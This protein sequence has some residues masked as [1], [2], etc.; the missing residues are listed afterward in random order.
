MTGQTV[1]STKVCETDPTPAAEHNVVWPLSYKLKQVQKD[2]TTTSAPKR[3]W[4]HTLYRGPDDRPVT[5]LYSKNKTE[6]EALAKMFIHEPVVGFDM[7]WPWNSHKKDRLQDKIGLI[8]VACEDK[9]GLFHIGL[10]S[11][12]TSEDL[13]APSLRTIIESPNIAKTGVAVLAAD[14]ARLAKFFKLRPQGAFELSHLHHLVM[15]SARKPDLVNT[16]LISLADLVEHHLGLPLSKG[17]VRTS[18]WSR[19]LN[20]KQRDYA[21]SDAYAGFMLYHCMNAKRALMNPIPPLP[22]HAERYLPL[23]FSKIVPIQLQSETDAKKI[24]TAD[25]FFDTNHEAE[26]AKVIGPGMDH[27]KMTTACTETAAN[28]GTIAATNEKTRAK[29]KAEKA[30]L[31]PISQA[32][33]DLLS[34]RRRALAVEHDVAPYLVASNV[35]L[36]GLARKRPL[37]ASTLLQVKGIGPRQQEKYGDQWLQVIQSFVEDT[38]EDA[39]VATEA[40][41][42]EGLSHPRAAMGPTG[43]RTRRRASRPQDNSPPSSPAF[44]TP[45]RRVPELHTGLSFTLAETKLDPLMKYSVTKSEPCPS[46]EDSPVSVT[47]EA[48]PS[49]KRKRSKS[50]D[51]ARTSPPLREQAEPLTPNSRIFR[52]KLEAYSKRIASMSK[53]RPV[54]PLVSTSV[55]D[56]IVHNPPRTKEELHRIPGITKLAEACATLDKDLLGT[57][58]KFSAA[59]YS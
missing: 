18:N 26:E 50:P 21:A 30:P 32:L 3:W 47:E 28:H 54:E 45:P 41:P 6:S 40:A 43:R 51:R 9:I 16:R 20:Q 12:T 44:G 55:L 7:E 19:A 10:H 13:I 4:S 57:I 17:S 36:E 24:L 42:N 37:D 29:C 39:G 34:Q 14:M 8:Q 58:V 15:F 48:L 31:D 56:H 2:T 25:D 27:E 22:M 23:S 46:S 33:F 59:R 53:P 38:G 1:E 52:S 5:V 11:G 35:V 49:G